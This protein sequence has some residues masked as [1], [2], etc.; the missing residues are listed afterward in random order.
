M[1]KSRD[2]T[3]YFKLKVFMNN[4]SIN[5]NACGKANKFS[6]TDINSA[7]VCLHCRQ[8]I[9]D[10]VVIE[11]LP[12]HFVPLS[13]AKVPLLVFMSGPNCSICKSFFEIFTKSARSHSGKVRFAHAYLPKNKAFA[14]KYKLRGVPTIALFKQGKLKGM[15]N[16]G[17]R[18]KELSQFIANSLS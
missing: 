18:P 15:V 5:C 13:K 12:H 14:T 4:L 3:S 10:G 9:L 1:Y 7:Q 11:M 2:P 6:L 16:G 17:M 8:S